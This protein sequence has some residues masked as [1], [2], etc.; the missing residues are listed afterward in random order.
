[1]RIVT[2]RYLP[3]RNLPYEGVGIKVK[4]VHENC[5]EVH[6]FSLNSKLTWLMARYKTQD[7]VMKAINDLNDTYV[8]YYKNTDYEGRQQIY[9]IERVWRFPDE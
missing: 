6:A 4:R 7:S 8:E 1:M 5:F 2:Q 9:Q 3:H